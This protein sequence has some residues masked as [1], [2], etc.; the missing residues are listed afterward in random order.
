MIIFSLL[1]VIAENLS[2]EDVQ[3]L[4]HMFSSMDTDRSGTI[5][6]EELKTGL[7]RLGS[8]V[9][10]VEVQQ[11]LEAVSNYKLSKLYWQSFM[12]SILILSL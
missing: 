1:K 9:T 3:G 2:E 4:K 11:L 6:F 7:K 5:T 12:K 10:E 8:T